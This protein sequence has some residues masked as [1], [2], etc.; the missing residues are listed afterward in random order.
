MEEENID[1]A[2]AQRVRAFFAKA[3]PRGPAIGVGF[4]LG[5]LAMGVV[6]CGECG[7]ASTRGA[8]S[9]QDASAPSAPVPWSCS[10]HPEI[11]QPDPGLCSICGM[12]LIPLDQANADPSRVVLSKRA[13]ALAQIQTTRVVHRPGATKQLEL[14]G[15]V[16]AH[17]KLVDSINAPATG[18]V[19][20][21]LVD[22][23][24][25]L[26]EVG[27]VL[28]RIH[29]PGVA[30]AHQALLDAHRTLDAGRLPDREKKRASAALQAAKEKLLALGASPQAVKH[31]REEDKTAY[32]SLPVLAPITG[33]VLD[34]NA[35]KGA[36]VAAGTPLFRVAD[37]SALWV[38]FDVHEKDL[39]DVSLGDYVQ[40]SLDTDPEGTFGG[41]VGFLDT[42]VNPITRVGQA[43]VH[44]NNPNWK[45]RPGMFARGLL[46]PQKSKE[47]KGKLVVPA[48]APLFTGRRAVVYVEGKW[49]GKPYYEPRTVRLAA[50]RG[51]VYPV[52][53]G[54]REGERVVT[55]GAFALDADLQ[56]RGGPSMMTGPDDRDDEPLYRPMRLTADELKSFQSLFFAYL[57]LQS[58][59]GDDNYRTARDSGP[60]FFSALDNIKLSANPK[61]KALLQQSRVTLGTQ[62]VA[63]R[64]A[65][66]LEGQR[67]VFLRI[68]QEMV[69]ILARHGNPMAFGLRLA[70]CPM[71]F[72][73]RGAYW[74]QKEEVVKNSYFGA[75]M[76]RCGDIVQRLD[77]GDF[78]MLPSDLGRAL[79]PSHEG[80]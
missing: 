30:K 13:R 53:A 56:I 22:A 9:S 16:T 26:V 47:S 41:I 64:N 52:I 3:V 8:G 51:D 14:L 75:T 57:D 5:L 71:A 79:K 65:K 11:K 12:D 28:A 1:P 60:R 20:K 50:R 35:D 77:P 10:M 24:G 36:Y 25:R 55:R 34:R 38:L 67:R 7:P 59:L 29:V 19:E 6:T 61:A 18:W 43:R 45:V 40:V 68:T 78:L 48:T 69:A 66:T 23:P 42:M 46:T 70:H 58:A 37:L 74:I 54:L 33:V 49:E 72:N 17:A 44:I 76:L 27:D 4:G 2:P 15:E 32:R 80:R 63:F 73:D 39:A 31:M 62:R 21:V